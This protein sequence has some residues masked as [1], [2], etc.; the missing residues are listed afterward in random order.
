MIHYLSQPHKSKCD[1]FKYEIAFLTD[2]K[3]FYEK[4]DSCITQLIAQHNNQN[5]NKF[6]DISEYNR[7]EIIPITDDELDKM[8]KYFY[9]DKSCLKEMSLFAFSFKLCDNEV[10]E[11]DE[12]FSISALYDLAQLCK[13]RQGFVDNNVYARIYDTEVVRG[14]NHQYTKKGAPYAW[15]KAKAYIICSDKSKTAI[16][17]IKA[18]IK[19]EVSI[20]CSVF[21]RICSICGNQIGC[22]THSKGRFYKN[23]GKCYTVIDSITDVYEWAFVQ[24]PMLSKNLKGE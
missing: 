9:I 19:N 15:I 5:G 21:D 13:G 8:G 2:D 7:C 16:D 6:D 23:G 22:C 1:D 20:S 10:D 12:Y 17:E 3:T 14:L 4:V 24:P 18:G 11:D